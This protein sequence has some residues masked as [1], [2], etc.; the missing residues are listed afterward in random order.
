MSDEELINEIKKNLLEPDDT[1]IFGC[2]Q[3]GSCCRN[4]EEE[5]I[6]TGY[7]IYNIAKGLGTTTA[8]AIMKYCTISLGPTSALPIAYLKER[9]DGSC[10]LLRKGLCTVQKDKPVVCR[11]YPIGRY[12]DGT[13]QRYFKQGA[14]TCTGLGQEIKLKDWLQEFNIPE[15]DEASELWGKFVI[16]ASSYAKKLKDKGKQ[17]KFA[18]FFTDVG[19]AFYIRY[20][21]SLPVEEN[22]KRNI[23]ILEEKYRNFKVL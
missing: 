7:D 14:G 6:I 5:I 12:Y 8:E 10:S 22:I 11:L 19:I 17:E 21:L 2:K 1:F 3:C 9:M 15:L 23:A 18:E 20:D 16:K 4:R 13:E